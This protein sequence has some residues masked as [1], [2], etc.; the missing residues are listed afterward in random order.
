MMF[1]TTIGDCE[2]SGVVEYYGPTHAPS[3]FPGCNAEALERHRDWL[4]PDY[5]MPHVDRFVIAITLW[6]LRRGDRT[7]LI[8]TGYGNGKR[9]G[10]AHANQL[11]TLTPEWLAAAGA[12]PETVTD[13]VATHLHADHVGWNT[14]ATPAGWEPTFRNAT[15][16]FPTADYEYFEAEYGMSPRPRRAA[17]FGDSVFPVMSAGQGR[18]YQPGDDLPGGLSAE[19][20]FG[21]TPGMMALWFE[22]EVANGV[23][24]ADIFHHPIQV[25]EPDWNSPA[26]IDAEASRTVRRAFLERIADTG[27]MFFPC[28]FPP[29]GYGTVVRTD[30]GFAFVPAQAAAR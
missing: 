25:A 4:V 28:H 17:G 11:N 16:H 3:K 6:V 13:V 18:L 19:P 9:R 1:Q 2:I 20:S 27:T 23:F 26:D 22:T 10:V 12:T 15:Y 21:H 5:W 29:P 14:V 30:K 7:I 24:C 8:D